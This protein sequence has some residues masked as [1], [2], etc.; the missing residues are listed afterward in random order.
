MKEQVVGL[1]RTTWREVVH[2]DDATD[3]E[4]ERLI[5]R[6]RKSPPMSCMYAFLHPFLMMRAYR[7]LA[8]SGEDV[9]VATFG[10]GPLNRCSWYPYDT[11]CCRDANHRDIARGDSRCTGQLLHHTSN[12]RPSFPLRD[13]QYYASKRYM[14]LVSCRPEKLGRVNRG[15]LVYSRVQIAFH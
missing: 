1:A 8:V 13:N 11:L 5:Q 10:L 3:E 2:R 15:H 7:Q 12:Y 6:A 4:K 14:Y 9:A